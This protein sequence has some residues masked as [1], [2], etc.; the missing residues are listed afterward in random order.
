MAVG[1]RDRSHIYR[2]VEIIVLY[3]PTQAN[4]ALIEGGYRKVAAS[5]YLQVTE[6][7]F[8]HAAQCAQNPAQY[9]AAR[10]GIGGE[11]GSHRSKNSGELQ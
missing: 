5:H 1:G 11:D 3:C 9:P 7:H 4:V 10:G 8:E 2:T 6:K